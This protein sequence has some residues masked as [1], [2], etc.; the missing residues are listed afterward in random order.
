MTADDQ[1]KIRPKQTENV[2][3]TKKVKQNK[4]TYQGEMIWIVFFQ[5]IPVNDYKITI[6]NSLPAHTNLIQK[7]W[8]YML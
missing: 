1:N 4:V 5:W 2:D 3:E 6:V 7:D 8:F